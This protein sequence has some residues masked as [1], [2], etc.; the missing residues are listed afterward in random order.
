MLTISVRMAEVRPEMTKTEPSMALVA[1][2]LKVTM[3][4]F[5]LLDR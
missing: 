2:T 4:S 1:R 3:V 5:F